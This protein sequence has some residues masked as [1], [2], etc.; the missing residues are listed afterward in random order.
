MAVEY[1]CQRCGAWV[2]NSALVYPPQHGLCFVCAAVEEMFPDPKE[3][4]E[5]TD[6]LNRDLRTDD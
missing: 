4:A 3:R 5:M 6:Y 1:L 2:F